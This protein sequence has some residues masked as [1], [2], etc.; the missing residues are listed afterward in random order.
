M[1]SKF[2]AVLAVVAISAMLTACGGGGGDGGGD[3]ANQG[4]G[5]DSARH[6]DVTEAAQQSVSGLIAYVN[7]LI[8]TMTSSTSESIRLGEAVLPT[9]DTT[10]PLAID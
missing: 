5:T 9:S 3:Q 2:R 8:T 1:Q 4:G 7:E 6:T 10:E